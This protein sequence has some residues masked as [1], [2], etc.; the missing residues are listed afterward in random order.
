MQQAIVLQDRQCVAVALDRLC[1]MQLSTNAHCH[2]VSWQY[3]ECQ[4]SELSALHMINS[5]SI[6][7]AFKAYC[8]ATAFTYQAP[9]AQHN[10]C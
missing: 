8:S 6:H 10:M 5:L 2:A 7:I 9:T 4:T 1:A 3:C